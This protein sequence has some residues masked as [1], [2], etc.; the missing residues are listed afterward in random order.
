MKSTSALVLRVGV[1]LVCM[2][3]EILVQ[4]GRTAAARDYTC[5]DC[6]FPFQTLVSDIPTLIG[7]H[8][9]VYR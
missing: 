4:N 1:L 3:I 2:L 5:S 6:V 7:G 9:D 8:I